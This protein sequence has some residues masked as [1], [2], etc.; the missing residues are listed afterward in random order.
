MNHITIGKTFAVSILILGMIHIAATFTPLIQ[1]GLE[2][3]DAGSWK[4]MIYMSL[5]C[6]FFFVKF[7]LIILLMLRKKEALSGYTPIFMPIGTGVFLVGALG[8]FYMPENPFAWLS[9]LLVTGVLG[10]LWN[11][12][13]K[14]SSP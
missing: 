11:I 7:G 9:F 1:A 12:K 10:S 3:L 13:K 8:L 5:V 4:A 6:G 2:C 14:I